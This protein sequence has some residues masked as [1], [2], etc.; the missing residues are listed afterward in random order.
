MKVTSILNILNVRSLLTSVTAKGYELTVIP[1]DEQTPLAG[2]IPGVTGQSLFEAMMFG[3]LIF[4]C[5]CLVIA[6]IHS[7]R[8][9]QRRINELAAQY[10]NRSEA[11][12]SWNIFSL[13]RELNDLECDVTEQMVQH[14]N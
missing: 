7:C 5:V 8:K 3:L 9:Y 6:Y 1:D 13:K 14:V 2:A 12:N 4:A 10:G 11:N